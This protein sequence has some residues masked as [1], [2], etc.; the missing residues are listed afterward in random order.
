VPNIELNSFRVKFRVIPHPQKMIAEVTQC[1]LITVKSH[2]I[3]PQRVG[4]PSVWVMPFIS[5]R[6]RSHNCP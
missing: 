2:S 3:V 4:P 5:R 1:A 6:C